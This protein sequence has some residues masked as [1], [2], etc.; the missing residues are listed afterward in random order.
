MKITYNKNP[1]WTTVELNETEQKELWY[2]VKIKEMEELLFEAYFNL[3]D[4]KH[5]DLDK[6]RKAVEP[7]YYMTGEEGDEN[8]IDKRCD[9]MVQW[10]VSELKGNHVGDCTCVACSC[11][12]CHAEDLIGINTIKG[13][14][15]HSAYKIQAAFGK[16]NEKTIDEA[17]DYLK[18][19]NPQKGAGWERFS[20]AD[21]DQYVPRWKSEARH[22]YD[23][24]LNYK[25][26]HFK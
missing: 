1:L 5:Y 4:G 9:E 24:L 7:D 21:F 15:K 13:L 12:K 11:L 25:N 14:G 18:K 17:L 26:E 22:A 3:R 8:N 6:A 2:K 16:N 10:Y 19:Y 23:W 20:Q